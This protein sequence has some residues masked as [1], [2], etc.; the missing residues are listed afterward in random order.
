MIKNPRILVIVLSPIF[1]NRR[2]FRLP[3]GI[4]IHNLVPP[5]G[6]IVLEY[7]DMK[8]ARNHLLQFI[9]YAG[10]LAGGL[11]LG[12]VLLSAATSLPSSA[13]QKGTISAVRILSEEG[14]YPLKGYPGRPIIYDTFTESLMLNIAY[15]ADA[16][17]PLKS[18]LTNMRYEIPHGGLN[19]VE[20]LSRLVAEERL[21]QTGYERYWHGYLVYLRPFL[22]VSTYEILRMII[23]MFILLLS[24][25]YIGVSFWKTRN[26]SLPLAFLI[27]MVATDAFSLG[28]LMQLSQVYI[29]GLAGG[30]VLLVLPKRYSIHTGLLF[31]GLGMVTA[32][33]D[34]LTAPLVALGIP[35]LTYGALHRAS[36]TDIFRTVALFFLGY[37]LF[38]ATK[39]I[40]VGL[41]YTPDA[42]FIALDQIK[43]RTLTHAG[44]GFSP[45]EAVL[46]NVFQLIGYDKLSK[47]VVL[48]LALLT[49]IILLVRRSMP[50]R[51]IIR[52]PWIVVILL[53]FL[54]YLLAANHSF[55]HVWYT[56][57]AQWVAV[58]SSAMLFFEI[59]GLSSH[60]HQ[61][62]AHT[63]TEE[64]KQPKR[65][66]PK[67]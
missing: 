1:G 23:M 50:L 55:L 67:P 2:F 11:A 25:L 66:N 35:L 21:P 5:W 7:T 33:F 26:P 28:G 31:F 39:W 29:I 14:L 46:R 42:W 40:V 58:A 63:S 32:F 27:A 45:L 22:A 4:S 37:G 62:E 19:Q 64:C 30:I 9:R 54:W 43:N 38:W 12:L 61:N 44:E 34:L 48:S 41:L 10:V 17:N 15:A 56:Y 13:L 49:T 53:P 18:A 60:R 3:I 16:K 36:R 51:Q 47:I 6:V 57:R 24:L 59:I 20:N 52:S 65:K 8:F